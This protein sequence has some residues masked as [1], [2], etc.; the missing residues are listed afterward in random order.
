MGVYKPSGEFSPRNETA[1]SW[2]WNFSNFRTVRNTFLMLRS[3]SLWSSAAPAKTN[4]WRL[5]PTPGHSTAASVVPLGRGHSG[6]V[7]APC[8]I[9]LIC[10]SSCFNSK[11]P[12]IP[13]LKDEPFP[14]PVFMEL[15]GVGQGGAGGRSAFPCGMLV[16]GPLHLNQPSPGVAGA[17]RL[18]VPNHQHARLQSALVP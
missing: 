2:V 3:P 11:F 8:S 16:L 6:R 10:F 12:V 14:G 18:M 5:T 13:L 4:T 1:G 17:G 9:G 15:P 7:W